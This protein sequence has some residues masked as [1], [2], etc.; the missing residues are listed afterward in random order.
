MDIKGYKQE[1]KS[2]KS[3]RIMMY[4]EFKIQQERRKNRM[5]KELNSIDT[6]I[7]NLKKR[8]KLIK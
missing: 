8:I 5:D 6:R 7:S 1:L 3:K 2:L 4:S